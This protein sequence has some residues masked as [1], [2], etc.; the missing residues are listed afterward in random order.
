MLHSWDFEDQAGRISVSTVGE[1]EICSVHYNCCLLN[2]ERIL[3]I[4]VNWI[5]Q[6]MEI[7]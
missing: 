4:L 3:G 2:F 5:I 1:V 7:D 6:R